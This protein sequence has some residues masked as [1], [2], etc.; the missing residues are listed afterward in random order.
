MV[1]IPL[2]V[3]F[4]KRN[5]VQKVEF[6]FHCGDGSCGGCDDVDDD[7]RGCGGRRDFVLR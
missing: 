1:I 4:K 5:E 7:G 3:Q 2:A 6:L